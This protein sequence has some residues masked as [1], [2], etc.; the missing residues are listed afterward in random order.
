VDPRVGLSQ[1]CALGTAL[2]AGAPLALVH[3]ADEATAE[4]AV[5][6]VLAAAT[7]AEPGAPPAAAAVVVECLGSA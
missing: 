4:A 7:L 2:Q 5:R 3:A 1:V 6:A